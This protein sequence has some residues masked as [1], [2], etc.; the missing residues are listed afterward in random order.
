MNHERYD[1]QISE[2]YL[3]LEFESDGPNGK[4][5]KVVRFS[6]RHSTGQTYFNL[7]F[8]DWNATDRRLDDHVVSNNADT[9]NVLAAVAATVLEFTAVYPEVIVYAKG[10]T[11]ARTR[12]Y[13]M[14]ISA[15]LGEIL[16]SLEI[17]GFRKDGNWELFQRGTN[18]L[19]FVAWRKD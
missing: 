9:K 8:G 19:G 2:S 11:P 3:D 18:Y 7:S 13:Q 1:F 4:I 12:L 16:F 17:Y 10:W 5:T 6:A 14:G 15:N